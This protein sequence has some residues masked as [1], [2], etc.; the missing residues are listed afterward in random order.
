DGATLREV[1]AQQMAM[2]QAHAALMQAQL[3]LLRG[4]PPVETVSPALPSVDRNGAN[5]HVEGAA[6]SVPALPRATAPAPAA[7]ERT[8]AMPA[9]AAE[10]A[11][12]GPHRPV[13][14]TLEQG[15]GHTERQARY[16]EEF[17]RRYTART[18]GSKAY[19]AE[20]R[21]ALADNRAALNFRMATKE[22]LYPVVG[23]RSEGSRLWD[24]DGNEYVDFT[25]GFGV[26]FF[27][28]RPAFIVEAVEE[29]LRRGFHL[30]PQSD[31]AGP[32]ARLFRE[33]TGMERVTFCNTGS[34]A[35]MTALRIARTA[36]GREKVVLFDGSYHGCFDGILARGAN[37][38]DGVPRSRPVAPGTPQGMVDDIVV[39][40]YGAPEALEYLRA[41][42]GEVAAV[43]VEPVQS[44][45]P[46]FHPVEFLREL[47]ALTERSGT[48]LVFDEMITG[49]RLGVKG[50][51]GFYGVEADLA[52]YGKVIGGGFPLGVVAGRASFMDAIDGGTWSYG[53]DSY[54]AANQTFFAG[55]FCK[56]PVVMAAAYAVL[57]HLRER[58]EAL[59]DEL[60]ART[61]RVVAALR[62]V[63]EEE[64]MPI[65]I[66]HC[67][68]LFRFAFRPREPIVD[69]LFYHMLERGIYIW[70]GR[71]CFLSTAHTD[72][73]CDR[74]VWALRDSI[75]ALRA[76][77]FLPERDGPGGGGASPDSGAGPAGVPVDLKLFPAPG[78]PSDDPRSFPLTPPQ[79]QVWVHAQLG[80]DA[81]RAYNEQIAFGVRGP[82]DAE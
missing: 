39:L 36:T 54:P 17:V 22:L 72:E 44:R 63:L 11:S 74:L 45:A 19:A 49:L 3:E 51:Q 12:H 53:D 65:R 41:H 33:L 69:L 57:R 61:A 48:A 24:V 37:G 60:H 59:Y 18:R 82:F 66:L 46:E 75:H 43:L 2:M 47:R 38:G 77:G 62:A 81:S 79:R 78:A 58:G 21:S 9:P 64:G 31:L 35:V 73:D 15:G 16:F 32:A 23:E 28:H 10:A 25:I 1:V 5:G 42:G 80:D 6:P 50:A 34:E 20:N 13:S 29:Q 40:Q 76:G 52:T 71:G 56:H 67:A 30:G 7:V 26:H 68:S 55:T 8:T 27:G 70:E 14:Q 4:A